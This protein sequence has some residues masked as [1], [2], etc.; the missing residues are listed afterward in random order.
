[1][2]SNTMEEQYIRNVLELDILTLSFSIN[3]LVNCVEKLY[4]PAWEGPKWEIT[5]SLVERRNLVIAPR[6]LYETEARSS[7]WNSKLGY[8]GGGGADWGIFMSTSP[9]SWPILFCVGRRGSRGH[10]IHTTLFAFVLHLAWIQP[11]FLF[12]HSATGFRRRMS[13]GDIRNGNLSLFVLFASF[14]TSSSVH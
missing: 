8:Q 2:T 3:P 1:M 13:E 10:S 11:T 12:V 6:N 9:G 14:L 4:V 7:I 5:A